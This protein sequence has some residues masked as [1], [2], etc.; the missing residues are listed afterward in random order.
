MVYDRKYL[1]EM[2][3]IVCL[4]KCSTV[5]TTDDTR[6]FLLKILNPEIIVCGG[7]SSYSNQNYI[8]RDFFHLVQPCIMIYCKSHTYKFF[9]EYI[10]SFI[11]VWGSG[12]KIC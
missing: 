11:S 2:V 1:R 9:V 7:N 6:A 12:V 10:N 5:I 8:S 3:E 4:S